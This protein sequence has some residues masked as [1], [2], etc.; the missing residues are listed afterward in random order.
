MTPKGPHVI[1]FL[2]PPTPKATIKAATDLKAT[3]W[4][5]ECGFD[6]AMGWPTWGLFAVTDCIDFAG[7]DYFLGEPQQTWTLPNID[8]LWMWAMHRQAAR[9][10]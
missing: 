5:A 7:Y 3:H 1:D 9:K 10:E 2:T 4:I 8:P 6:H